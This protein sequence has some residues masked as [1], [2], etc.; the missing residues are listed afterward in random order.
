MA[1]MGMNEMS[2]KWLHAV[3]VLPDGRILLERLTF[4]QIGYTAPAEVKWS[5][6]IGVSSYGL[7]NPNIIPGI[8]SREMETLSRIMFRRLGVKILDSTGLQVL[9]LLSH[10]QQ[11]DLTGRLSH[12]GSTM[13][14]FRVKAFN[15][16][17]LRL[18]DN[19]E[20]KALFREEIMSNLGSGMFDEASITTMKMI[21]AMHVNL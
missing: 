21:E 4:N 1:V 6:S 18:S 17:E 12:T 15:N 16:V 10:K 3:F 13:E 5:I 2:K 9:H 20:V 11:S 7:S 14:V 8:H 19:S